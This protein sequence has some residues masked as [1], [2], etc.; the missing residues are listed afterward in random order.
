MEALQMS[1]LPNIFTVAVFTFLICA[2]ETTTDNNRAI[3]I[4]VFF[5][6][7]IM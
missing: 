3:V 2:L 7:F 1:Q 6:E 4:T 5:S